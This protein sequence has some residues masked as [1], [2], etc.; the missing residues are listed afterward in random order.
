MGAVTDNIKIFSC[1]E[2]ADALV[3]DICKELKVKRGSLTRLKFKNDN[4]F[5]QFNESVR[6]ADVFLVQTMNRPVNERIIEL[7]L[8]ID[9]AKRSSA[10]NITVVLPYYPYSRSDKKDQPRIPITAK[11]MATLIE[12]AGANRILTCD[13][14]NPSIQAYFEIPCDVVSCQG[15]LESYFEKEDKENIVVVATDAGSSK[16]AFKY[17]EYYDADVALIN[18]TRIGNTDAVSASSIIGD[19]KGRIALVFD[20]EIDTGGSIMAAAQMLK[21]NGA[22]KILVGCVHGVLSSN[23]TSRIDDSDVEELVITDTIPN[24]KI[25]SPKITVLSTAKIFAEAIRGIN[26][27]DIKDELF[28]R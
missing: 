2:D 6:M 27:D 14:H 8:A 12:A 22:S 11:L 7:L 3:E 10:K 20:D 15:L 13:L 9:A 25:N 1:S 26:K 18:K 23:A 5:I 28:E 24:K 19:I 16:K 21:N 4:N 17:A